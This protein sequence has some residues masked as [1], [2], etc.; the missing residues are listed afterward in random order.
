VLEAV[1]DFP[2]FGQRHVLAVEQQ[3]GRQDGFAE[4][5][6]QRLDDAMLGD[7]QADGVVL[8]VQQP[9]GHLAGAAQDK[10]IG[11]RRMRLENAELGIV[12]L[13]IAP[14]LGQ[15][16]AD[17]GEIVAAVEAADTEQTRGRFLVA[18]LAA[19]GIAG[20]GGINDH[21]ALLENLHDLLDQAL[22]RV[23]A[24]DVEELG[25]KLCLFRLS[26]RA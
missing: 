11:S 25:H 15:V 6:Q 20:V 9:L 12:D 24:V 23:V 16:A 26:R 4:L 1:A 8:L 18:H 22:L 2:R 14:Q 7:T 19:E 17:Q 10:G 3:R 5:A 21:A 13:G